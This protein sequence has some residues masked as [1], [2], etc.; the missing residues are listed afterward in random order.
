MMKKLILDVDTGVDD[1]QA[2]MMALAAPNVEILGITCTHGNTILQNILKNTLRVLKVCNR[3]DIP[4]YPGFNEPL[5]GRKV[6]VAGDFHGKDGLGDVPD[7]DAPG[8]QL[9]QEMNAVQAI[10]S[11]VSKYPGEVSLVATG[12]LT[13]LALAVK[14]DPTLPT[15]L[16]GLYIMGGNIE[17]RGNTT[18]CGEFNF[19]ADPEAAYIVLDCYTCPTT[20]ASWEFSCRNSLP[21]SFCDTWLAQKTPKARFMESISAHTRKIAQTDRF[22]KELV[23]G[24]GFNTCDTYAVAAAIC[25]NL[26]TE[27]EEVAVTVEL[28]GQHTRGMMVLDYIDVLHKKHKVTILKKIDIEVF[29]QLLINALK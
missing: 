3:L 6:H 11:I 29:K 25:D 20:I 14:M 7:P 27:S 18:A 5:L 23:A 26:V 24:P 17:S 21:W 9:L 15:K 4:V 10:I 22:Q 13:N 12:P 16:K 2:I 19:L 28:E 8:L 1:A